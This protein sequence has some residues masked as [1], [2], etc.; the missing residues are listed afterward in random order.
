MR[1]E[2]GGDYGPDRDVCPVAFQHRLDYLELIPYR[3][4]PLPVP[5]NCGD[6]VTASRRGGR[7]PVGGADERGSIAD[8]PL[9]RVLKSHS[10]FRAGSCHVD[11]WQR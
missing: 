7:W 3:L 5:L 11:P 8:S 9:D 4:D 10:R 2:A 1:I 6:G